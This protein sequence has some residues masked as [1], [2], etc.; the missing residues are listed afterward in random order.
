MTHSSYPCARRMRRL[1]SRTL[2]YRTLALALGGFSAV[3]CAAPDAGAGG[4]MEMS[5]SAD[6]EFDSAF[7]SGRGTAVDVSRFERGA[8][9]LPGE[10]R[11]DVLVNGI[12]MGR[13]SL[14]FVEIDDGS[15]QPC[16][17]RGLLDGWG[18]ATAALDAAVASDDAEF[19]ALPQG[20]FCAALA[21]YIPEATLH[22]DSSE[23]AVQVS[24][25]Q[26]Y[27]R[28]QARGWVDPS[29]WDAGVASARLG[30][31]V[32]VFHGQSGGRST[33]SGY[34]GLR[35]DLNLG[36][37]Q[38]HH[39]GN[40]R[41][42]DHRQAG[43]QALS[44]HAQRD[45]SG[46]RAQ[47]VL[48]QTTTAGTLFNSVGFTGARLYSDER[49]LPDSQRGYAPTVRGTAA[50]NAR[51]AIYQRGYLM[52]E[53]T[54]APGPFIIDDLYP[55]GF[56][57]D[58][59]VVVT[60]ADGRVQRFSVPFAAV[61]QLL[62]PG[63]HRFSLS[64]GRLRGLRGGEAPSLFEATWQQGF[65]NVLTGYGGGLASTGYAALQL[66]AA[67]NT[68]WGAFAGDLTHSR[69][70]LP[71]ATA[72]AG[73]EL[74]GQSVRLSYSKI[75]PNSGTNF[76][77]AAYR[78][79]TDGYLDLLDA[80]NLRQSLRDD[81]DFQAVARQRSR[82]EL[83]VSQEL[84]GSGGRLWVTGNS[85]SFWNRNQRQ[86][87]F[88]AGYS[89]RWRALSY[90]LSAQRSRISQLVG[91][92]SGSTDRTD[93][94][95]NLSVSLPL[96]S[97]PRAP[98]LSARYTD[99]PAAQAGLMLNASPTEQF[100]YG[101]A[102]DRYTG[103]QGVM[104][105]ANAGYSAPTA[106]FDASYSHGDGY[107]QLGLGA[108]GGLVAHAGGVTLAQDMGDT[109]GIVHADNAVGAMVGGSRSLK[110]DR[111]GYAVVPYLTPYRMNDISLDPK[112]LPMEVE[113][114][115]T[116]AH[117]APRAGAVVL[118]EFA[119]RSGGQ[120]ALID[121]SQ[122][123]GSPLPFGADVLDEQGNPVGVVGQASRLWLRGIAPQGVLTV[124]WGGAV[125][126][127]CRI[128]Y[129]LP[130]APG[131]GRP[132]SLQAQCLPIAAPS[133]MTQAAADAAEPGRGP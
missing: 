25:P 14:R 110:V 80:Q 22:F 19:P 48:G 75:L 113:L 57:S 83:N 67:V 21:G 27:S 26:A 13:Q 30:Y 119:T 2:L 44:S 66:G 47:L 78:Y 74:T 54:V 64:A 98:T 41:W 17:S 62:R 95:Y 108:R 132:T 130:A 32:N 11:V 127:Q 16:L 24:L 29:Q 72:E 122:P 68:R 42:G 85:T 89:G 56:G 84:R 63:S 9:V 102:L 43:Y 97:A 105:N 55:T 118:M 49:M 115:T 93:T 92:G 65:S 90:T 15:V 77:L 51:V 10:Y 53:V 96:G 116:L 70:A 124:S 34:L 133:L 71:V 39:D 36:R 128:A 1:P 4:G 131:N 46:L 59:D 20:E 121:A 40:Y 31:D 101:V 18:V 120:S 28:R 7:F 114:N 81:D 37:W 12:W 100:N 52:Q 111:R 76:S 5:A 91:A 88:T 82:L 61:P 79:S 129:A 23:M 106:M 94:Q 86:L 126:Q 73:R 103:S 8:G 123:D 99:G 112:G 35:T 38:L 107:R 45:L 87:S 104:L 3:A 33:S 6:V 58:L 60:E 125:G 50:T 109:V 117:S 69:T